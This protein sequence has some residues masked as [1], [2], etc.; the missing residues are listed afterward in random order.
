ME[1]DKANE[2]EL[3]RKRRDAFGYGKGEDVSDE[4]DDDG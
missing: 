1:A 2:K 4:S 3:K